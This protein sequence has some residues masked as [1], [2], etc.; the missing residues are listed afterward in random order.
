VD[1]P[2]E[3]VPLEPVPLD[4]VLLEPVP[5]EPVPL[6]PVPLVA[7]C[8]FC[9]S[10]WWKSASEAT[11]VVPRLARP[12]MVVTAT[13]RRFPLVRMLTVGPFELS[14]LLRAFSSTCGFFY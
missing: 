6:D 11:P 7:V 14:F 10:V 3:L 13:A 9:A 4:P 2:D 8:A 1:V 5:L 12:R